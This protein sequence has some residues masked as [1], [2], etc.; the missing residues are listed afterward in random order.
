MPF[1]NKNTWGKANKFGI[2]CEHKFCTAISLKKKLLRKELNL[3][4]CDK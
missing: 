2:V 3:Q 1:K 4:A